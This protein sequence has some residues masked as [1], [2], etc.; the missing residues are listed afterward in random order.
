MN[1][2]SGV[3][4]SSSVNHHRSLFVRLAALSLSLSVLIAAL[5]LRSFYVSDGIVHSTGSRFAIISSRGTINFTSFRF[6]REDLHESS[7]GVITYSFVEVYA[8]HPRTIEYGRTI[9]R[10]PAHAFFHFERLKHT[11]LTLPPWHLGRAVDASAFQTLMGWEVC[12]PDWLTFV[13]AAA[14]TWFLWTRRGPAGNPSHCQACGYDLRATPER[15]PECGTIPLQNG[16][17]FN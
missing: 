8:P 12:I 15:C 3:L 6:G 10:L 9:P 7:N 16:S 2:R 14:A 4:E 5:I 13:A 17:L 11:P 1:R